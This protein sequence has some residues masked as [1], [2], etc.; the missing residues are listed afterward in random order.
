M[1]SR[2][3]RTSTL[4]G[5]IWCHCSFEPHCGG[6][7]CI[8]SKKGSTKAVLQSINNN[9][10]LTSE[11]IN[12]ALKVYSSC[13]SYNKLVCVQNI[14]KVVQNPQKAKASSQRT[15]DS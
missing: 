5:S 3:V 1:R 4:D 14:F 12:K 9:L 15:P 7:S 11:T 8:T 13:Y 6:G 10:L 2:Q